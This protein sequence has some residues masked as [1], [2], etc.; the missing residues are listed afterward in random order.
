MLCFDPPGR[1]SDSG[2]LKAQGGSGI[3]DGDGD[4]VLLTASISETFDFRGLAEI[5]S[6]RR[7]GDG[8]QSAGLTGLGLGSSKLG[9]GSVDGTRFISAAGKTF[10]S[11]FVPV[12]NSNGLGGGQGGKLLVRDE[13]S[14]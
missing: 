13:N 7:W 6:C 2:T 9:L 12:I 1:D 14:D 10:L 5:R 8:V 4:G 3:V 11:L